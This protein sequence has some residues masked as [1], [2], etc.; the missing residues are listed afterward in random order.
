MPILLPYVIFIHFLVFVYF[1]IYLLLCVSFFS[2]SLVFNMDPSYIVALNVFVLPFILCSILISQ[3][4]VNMFSENLL[5]LYSQQLDFI[6]F[7]FKFQS[8][9]VI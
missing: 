4:C 3:I 5:D 1:L 7:F 8:K 9:M 6:Y 2:H